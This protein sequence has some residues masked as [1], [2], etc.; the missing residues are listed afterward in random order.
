MGSYALVFPVLHGKTD[1]DVRS[2]AKMLS[3][4][5]AAYR[6]ARKRSGVT[7]E[8]AYLQKTPM[9]DFVVAYLEASGDFGPTMAAMV[10]SDHPVD[11][12]FVDLVREIHGIDLR[13]PPAGPP[14]ETLA[15]WSDPEVKTRGR[16]MAFSAPVAPGKTAAGR[17]FAKEAFERRLA[18]FAASRR[19]LHENREVITLQ[20]TPQGDVI[21]VYLEGVDPFDANRRFAAST[22]AYDTWFRAQLRDVFPPFVDF[23]KP[24]PGVEEIFDSESLTVP[25]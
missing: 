21:N 11:R 10:S 5:P 19:A 20:P 18:E 15:A 6:E 25:A 7:L 16:G 3:A 1:T 24:V 4:D 8:R 14:P 13:Q 12:K 17:A 2:I 23:D 9:G 22:S